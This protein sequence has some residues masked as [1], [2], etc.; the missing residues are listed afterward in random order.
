[1]LLAY[2]TCPAIMSARFLALQFQNYIRLEVSGY[3]INSI[4]L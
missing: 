4:E 2:Y 1:M 3:E